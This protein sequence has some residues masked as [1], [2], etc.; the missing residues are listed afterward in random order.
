MNLKKHMH[1]WLWLEIANKNI[2]YNTHK[3]HRYMQKPIRTTNVAC[4]RPM[5]NQSINKAHQSTCSSVSP[6]VSRVVAGGV[7]PKSAAAD[8]VDEDDEHEDA[9]VDHCQ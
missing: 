7:V 4:T 3:G 8:G 5:I 1:A 6:L 9:R 2:S